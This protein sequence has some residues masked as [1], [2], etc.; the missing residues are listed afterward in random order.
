MQLAYSA[1]LFSYFRPTTVTIGYD[2]DNTNKLYM[3]Y[4]VNCNYNINI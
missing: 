2:I 4:K 1:I 3:Q